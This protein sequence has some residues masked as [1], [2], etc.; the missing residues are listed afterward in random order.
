MLRSP[1]GFFWHLLMGWVWLGRHCGTKLYPTQLWGDCQ[2]LLE[3]DWTCAQYFGEKFLYLFAVFSL[4][5]AIFLHQ[6]LLDLHYKVNFVYAF[7]LTSV[8][9]LQ[10]QVQ[11]WS[12]SCSWVPKLS[13]THA[14][15]GSGFRC[16][17]HWIP[18]IHFII[19][20][21][22]KLCLQNVFAKN[23]FAMFRKAPEVGNI[24]CIFL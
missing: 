10:H 20:C 4:S 17:Q 7:L 12:C 18:W 6:S 15:G 8:A 3:V 14:C 11:L 1:F 21:L 9:F 2:G 23:Y 13:F 19:V 24:I 5:Y 16:F 22:N